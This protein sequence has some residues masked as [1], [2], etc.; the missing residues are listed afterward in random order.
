M[1]RNIITLI[2]FFMTFFLCLSQVRVEMQKKGG[3][4][5]VPC[6]INNLNLKFI[7]DTGASKVS[8]S[9]SIAEFMLENGYLSED[10]VFGTTTLRQA[11]GS[12]YEAYKV[13]IRKIEIGGLVMYNVEGVISPK[14]NSPLLLGM[15]AIQ[16][17]GKV[18]IQNEYLFID[19][20]N[21]LSP[22]EQAMSILGFKP[23]MDYDLCF[24]ILTERY[25]EDGFYPNYI[26]DAIDALTVEDIYIEDIHFDTMK[27]AFDESDCL[28]GVA[29]SVRYPIKQKMKALNVFNSLNNILSKKYPCNKYIERNN[30]NKAYYFGFEEKDEVESYP[31]KIS[32]WKSKYEVH[33][34]KGKL[35]E[36]KEVFFIEVYYWDY[37]ELINRYK[38]QS[39]NY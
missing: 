5:E 28:S 8:L 29:L 4:Y 37:Q 38:P 10:D 11:D 21:N 9:M 32:F 16:K 36:K 1:K 17:L 7:F 2:I 31:I 33:N 19:N 18:S 22:S 12:T 13:N 34:N 30:N 6:T 24:D 23:G 25:G 26:N 27:L 35:L 14:Q 3:V 20:S 39:T 15:T